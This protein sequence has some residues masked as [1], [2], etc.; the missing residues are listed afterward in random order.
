MRNK[1]SPYYKMLQ[2]VIDWESQFVPFNRPEPEKSKECELC[3]EPIAHG[4]LCGRCKF[5][6]INNPDSA[7]AQKHPELLEAAIAAYRTG[8]EP[9]PGDTFDVSS[10]AMAPLDKQAVDIRAG[11]LEYDTDPEKDLRTYGPEGRWNE[12]VE[13]DTGDVDQFDPRVPIGTKVQVR[14]GNAED[15]K[16]NWHIEG[17]IGWVVEYATDYDGDTNCSIS[18][19]P[20]GKPGTIIATVPGNWIV[21]LHESEEDLGEVD[22]VLT[23]ATG[24]ALKILRVFLPALDEHAEVYEDEGSPYGGGK[25]LTKQGV[26]LAI[27]QTVKQLGLHYED[28]E[29]ALQ[30]GR[31]HNFQIPDM[32]MVQGKWI[33]MFCRAYAKKKESEQY[34]YD[35]DTPPKSFK[36]GEEVAGDELASVERF[37]EPIQAARLDMYGSEEEPMGLE[38]GPYL[39]ESVEEEMGDVSGFEPAPLQKYEIYYRVYTPGFKIRKTIHV[40]A[41]NALAALGIAGTYATITN[42]D[43][44][45]AKPTS[46]ERAE[47][48]QD[49]L[50]QYETYDE[51]TVKSYLT[52]MSED[53]EFS[54]RVE[55]AAEGVIFETQVSPLSEEVEDLE[56]VDSFESPDMYQTVLDILSSEG[57]SAEIRQGSSGDTTYK[58]IYC[59][60]IDRPLAVKEKVEG[61]KY[62]LYGWDQKPYFKPGKGWTFV[63]AFTLADPNDSERYLEGTEPTLGDL[64]KGNVAVEQPIPPPPAETI[65]VE[66]PDTGDVSFAPT[67]SAWSP[68]EQAVIDRYQMYYPQMG[69]AAAIAQVSKEMQFPYAAAFKIIT[70]YNN[71]FNQDA[72]EINEAVEDI[73]LDDDLGDV[74]SFEDGTA[75]GAE[76]IVQDFVDHL[77]SSKIASVYHCM[78]RWHISLRQLIAAFEQEKANRAE[79]EEEP[80]S[81]LTRYLDILYKIRDIITSPKAKSKLWKASQFYKLERMNESE[82]LVTPAQAAAA[83]DRGDGTKTPGSLI[84]VSVGTNAEPPSFDDEYAAALRELNESEENE[85]GSVDEFQKPGDL[86]GC[87]VRVDIPP[88]AFSD[89]S[90]IEQRANGRSGYVEDIDEERQQGYGPWAFILFEESN[91]Y[92]LWLPLDWLHFRAP[93]PDDDLDSLEEATASDEDDLGGIESFEDPVSKFKEDLQAC[94]R[95]GFEELQRRYPVFEGAS[96]TFDHTGFMPPEIKQLQKIN[97]EAFASIIADYMKEQ[98]DE[99]RRR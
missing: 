19:T 24:K 1:N 92:G 99:V 58:Y 4:R 39:T 10:T 40:N 21:P 87:K 55:G 74:S 72:Y 46:E 84:N 37:P 27:D 73:D 57:I 5:M 54:L 68:E 63:V 44:K 34:G 77:E 15:A 93:V 71:K 98:E 97:P 26:Q 18:D 56:D 90:A 79:E 94:C 62:G 61:L 35:A 9:L 80:G 67:M 96:L 50:K 23:G 86:I 65:P 6:L 60:D 66:E 28:I 36:L 48:K 33:E 29:W 8:L 81:V 49:V 16:R 47:F 30:Y 75:G 85:F 25:E 41:R 17:K 32:D 20:P 7:Y 3:G 42:V 51:D 52:D 76:E 2:E 78:Q 38:N 83:Y 31:K 82:N 95:A 13:D 70:A 22:Q 69:D 43:V 91:G 64:R 45:G 14:A 88:H 89:L 11:G 59:D 12:S 53:M